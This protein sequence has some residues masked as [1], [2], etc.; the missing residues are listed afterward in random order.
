M[1]DYLSRAYIPRP[2]RYRCNAVEVEAGDPDDPFR[3]ELVDLS[4]DGFRL[5]LPFPLNG[6]KSI[7]VRLCEDA[8]VRL[9]LTGLIRWQRSDDGKTWMLGCQSTERIGLETLGEL[10]LRGILVVEDARV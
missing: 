7:S 1:A 9:T 10:L 8:G 3:A 6:R 2:P 4:R 5:R